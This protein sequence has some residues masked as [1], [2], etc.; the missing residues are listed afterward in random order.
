MI[1]RSKLF[2]YVVAGAIAAPVAAAGLL[3]QTGEASA[4]SCAQ[5]AD[6]LESQNRE[7][8]RLMGRDP[9]CM[10]KHASHSYSL[11]TKQKAAWE[12]LCEKGS[13]SSY[14]QLA[15]NRDKILKTCIPRGSH[16]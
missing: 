4:L 11:Q 5:I 16:D 8:T 9:N 12:Q 14:V 3:M 7:V 6:R 2:G 10:R 15:S 1:T 13:N